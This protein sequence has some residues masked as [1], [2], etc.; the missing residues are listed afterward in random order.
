MRKIGITGLI[1]SG[2]SFVGNI[3]R[4]RGYRVLDADV[5]V[6]DL[7][8]DSNDLRAVVRCAFGPYCL[9]QDGVNRQF[10]ADLIFKDSDARR[11]L[12]ALVDPYLAQT[13]LDFFDERE[14]PSEKGVRFFEAALMHRLPEVSESLD[15]VWE[16]TASEGVRLKRL[17]SRGISQ[18]DAY[19]R[20][21]TQRSNPPFEH[22]HIR[23]IN[24]DG[25]PDLLVAAV[26]DALEN[27][28]K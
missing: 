3:L 25:D 19:R 1:G 18:V 17:V 21:E 14:F 9:T 8:R 2:K 26:L 28:L 24:N 15:E 7:Y 6:H 27:P 16:V 13:A 20:I 23:K 22:P 4:E 5:A 11:R 12:E 10:F